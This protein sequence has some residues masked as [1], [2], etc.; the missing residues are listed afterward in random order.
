MTYDIAILGGSGFIARHLIEHFNHA[1]FNYCVLGRN[2]PSSV[3]VEN[4]YRLDL[5]A[6]SLSKVLSENPHIQ[7]KNLIFNSAL[8]GRF[9]SGSYDEQKQLQLNAPALQDLAQLQPS[10]HGLI[11][12]GSSE[13]Y[14]A[15]QS[16]VEVC[17]DDALQPLSSYGNSKVQLYQNGLSWQK[18]CGQNYMHLRPFNVIG[19]GAD[20]QMFVASLIQTL[21]KDE[22]FK[23]TL[24]EQ[25]RSFVSVSTLVRTIDRLLQLEN[26]SLI[27]NNH[28]LNVS[29][30][31]YLQMKEVAQLIASLIPKG[32]IT[33]GALDYRPDEIWHQKPNLQNLVKLIGPDFEPLLETINQMISEQK[34][35]L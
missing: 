9:K 19:P 24:G 2:R 22:E 27:S 30:P 25:F 20:P 7:F 14:G 6:A 35:Q 5:T 4:F 32:R 11:T 23:M 34:S 13:E 26:W 10:L 31:D 33:F 3:K 18:L 28:A 15:R 8:K 17:E 29:S 1:G 16:S 21:L 12:I